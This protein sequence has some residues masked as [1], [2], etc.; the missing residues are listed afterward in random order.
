MAN[1]I[2]FKIK[3]AFAFVCVDCCR[4]FFMHPISLIRHYHF[5]FQICTLTQPLVNPF[6][7]L[8]LVNSLETHLNE[9]SHI[10][11]FIN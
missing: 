8:W 10:Y 6:F 4:Q 3:K 1:A 2:N 7:K 5:V 11:L 9:T